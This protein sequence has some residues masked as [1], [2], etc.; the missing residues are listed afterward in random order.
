M[1]YDVLTLQQ[2]HE[3]KQKR[4]ASRFEIVN[5]ALNPYL[6]SPEPTKVIAVRNSRRVT[7]CELT[8]FLV[9][10]QYIGLVLEAGDQ[11]ELF[12]DGKNEVDLL[13]ECP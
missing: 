1:A 9:E 6:D 4:V 3:Y 12:I 13:I 11:I 7:L 5:A 8:P 2:L 10:N